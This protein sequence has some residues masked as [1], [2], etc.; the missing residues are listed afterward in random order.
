[1]DSTGPEGKGGSTKRYYARTTK[2]AGNYYSNSQRSTRVYFL[3][4]EVGVHA[5]LAPFSRSLR[6]FGTK[7][8]SCDWP[9]ALYVS[10]W[11][12]SAGR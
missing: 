10:S 6:V 4:A 8:W 1:M 11:H 7:D 5:L 2:T 3:P 9:S 12:I